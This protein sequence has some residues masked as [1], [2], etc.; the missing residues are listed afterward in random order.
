MDSLAHEKIPF[1]RR[2]NESFRP[3]NLGNNGI[4][5]RYRPESAVVTLK[6]NAKEL[7]STPADDDRH[8]EKLRRHVRNIEGHNCCGPF[9]QRGSENG[10]QLRL[11]LAGRIL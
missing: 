8:V 6:L 1:L 3:Q 2:R 11:S 4:Y 9:R 5:E 10:K 7:L